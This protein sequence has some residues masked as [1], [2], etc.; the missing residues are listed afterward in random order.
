MELVFL[1][2]KISVLEIFSL[3]NNRFSHLNKI[4][5]DTNVDQQSLTKLEDLSLNRTIEI[6]ITNEYC[7]GEKEAQ[8]K[9][10]FSKMKQMNVEDVLFLPKFKKAFITYFDANIAHKIAEKSSI[11]FF[12]INFR[13]R[14]HRY[15]QPDVFDNRAMLLKYLPMSLSIKE[16]KNYGQKLTSQK[17]QKIFVSEKNGQDCIFCFKSKIDFDRILNNLRKPFYQFNKKIEAQR[18]IR[19]TKI[20][21]I[22]NAILPGPVTRIT[23]DEIKCL[24]INSLNKIEKIEL[25]RKN[26]NEST[27]TFNYFPDDRIFDENFNASYKIGPIFEEFSS[28]SEE[29][30]KKPNNIFK[31]FDRKLSIL[32]RNS[33]WR[34]D[35]HE[36]INVI[37]GK[38]LERQNSL[39][40]K[41]VLDEN[42]RNHEYLVNKWEREVNKQL[43]LILNEYDCK[44]VKLS[45]EYRDSLIK[46]ACNY[47]KSLIYQL[48]LSNEVIIL[49]GKKIHL[50]EFM[51]HL[52]LKFAIDIKDLIVPQIIINEINLFKFD[53]LLAPLLK[54]V[55]EKFSLDRLFYHDDE[56]KVTAKGKNALID[57]AFTLINEYL[58]NIDI[59]LLESQSPDLLVNEN[60]KKIVKSLF[61]ELNIQCKIE[62]LLENKSSS[63][64]GIYLVYFKEFFGIDPSIKELNSNIELI[65]QS[66]FQSCEIELAKHMS[67]LDSYEW[68]EF[69]NEK[70]CTLAVK[71]NF[72]CCLRRKQNSCQLLLFGQRDLVLILKQDIQNFLEQHE[73]INRKLNL[74]SKEVLY[75]RVI[76]PQ[77]ESKL[78]EYNKN[79]KIEF[80]SKLEWEDKYKDVLRHDAIL[81][82][83]PN[84]LYYTIFSII[85]TECSNLKESHIEFT[86]CP[87]FAKLFSKSNDE[88]KKDLYEIEL[89]TNTAIEYSITE[90]VDFNLANQ[91]HDVVHHDSEVSLSVNNSKIEL[92][93]GD[94]LQLN[95][96]VI[97]NSAASSLNLS[98]GQLSKKIYEKTGQIVQK[99]CQIKYPN[100]IKQGEVAVTSSGNFNNFKF[101]WHVTVGSYND[102][103]KD[104]LASVSL[105]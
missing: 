1:S 96:N 56:R 83:C 54:L 84:D 99:E 58:N 9:K 71:P 20:S 19:S 22:K 28:V 51:K 31:E 77:F 79:L 37:G 62:F 94:I 38:V 64:P 76:Y 43:D 92:F 6:D 16:L 15:S 97:V 93:F 69:Y 104:Q 63:R 2:M 26:I 35:F 7:T 30:L 80:S 87:G 90:N 72:V 98:S 82:N 46:D 41:C 89:N 14:L 18:V 50:N 39:V 95:G 59:K 66:Y 65:Y 101:I 61:S 24:L 100:G 86:H 74:S 11:I 91:I 21:I 102:K 81:L 40:I 4:D 47:G 36:R 53:D 42:S 17:P 34:K 25:D 57:E 103:I 48:D 8:L 55:K 10:Y 67:L 32:Y 13:V 33:K 88:F 52:D 70:L 29:T 68:K 12:D 75:L 73:T 105:K 78:K 85:A 45:S 27:I 49:V 23:E 5:P 44:E 3:S 60:M